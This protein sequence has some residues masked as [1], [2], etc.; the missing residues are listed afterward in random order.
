MQ[1]FAANTIMQRNLPDSEP[2]ILM[3]TV[4]MRTPIFS[5]SAFK[6]SVTYFMSFFVVI[7]IMP[8]VLYTTYRMA[9]ERETKIKQTLIANGLN[10]VIHFL[11]WFI[12]Y[13]VINLVLSL[14]VVLCIKFS[15]FKNDGFILL[16]LV[17][18]LGY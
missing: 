4:P 6:I 10:P 16:Y 1:I 5:S 15:V 9:Y 11:S 17:V 12:H 14:L 7:T 3:M 8:L 2:E 18:F 13:T